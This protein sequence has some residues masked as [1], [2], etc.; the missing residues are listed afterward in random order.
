MAKKAPI[1][2]RRF[3]WYHAYRLGTS[4]KYIKERWK[5]TQKAID[6]YKSWRNR[7]I[8]NLVK[9]T[10]LTQH[11]LSQMSAIPP[12]ISG[13]LTEMESLDDIT[14]L[15]KSIQ[16]TRAVWD[17]RRNTVSSA[18]RIHERVERDARAEHELKDAQQVLMS[19]LD[20]ALA[21]D[22]ETWEEFMEIVSGMDDE[23]IMKFYGLD[24]GILFEIL[25]IS[26]PKLM[27]RMNAIPEEVDAQTNEDRLA[28]FRNVLMAAIGEA[29]IRYPL[30]DKV[31]K[32]LKVKK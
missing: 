11:Q 17:A 26:S 29:D 22:S 4:I 31:R 27:A 30:K 8:K 13:K 21:M 23:D 6:A 16:K 9:K 1:Q 19:R 12:R 32:S 5:T 28:Y 20:G 7:Y 2:A 25:R 18:E 24:D 14:R 10:G 3:Y 15:L